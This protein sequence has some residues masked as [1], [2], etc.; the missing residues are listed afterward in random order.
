[1]TS[2]QTAVVSLKF[3]KVSQNHLWGKLVITMERFQEEGEQ[4]DE[5]GMRSFLLEGMCCSSRASQTQRALYQPAPQ[6]CTATIKLC[7]VR[8]LLE[9]IVRRPCWEAGLGKNMLHWKGNSRPALNAMVL[10]SKQRTA[11]SWWKRA[12]VHII[13]FAWSFL[14]STRHVALMIKNM[15]FT[16][17]K[18]NFH[19][20][21]RKWRLTDPA[22]RISTLISLRG[23]VNSMQ[24]QKAL[25]NHNISLQFL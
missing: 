8:L 16:D 24:L 13:Y 2:W 3:P 19:Q 10:W 7:N 6:R 22:S 15:P 20:H 17:P 4:S 1:M 25:N 12:L 11:S 21:V 14:R 18:F 9:P 5:G 23:Q